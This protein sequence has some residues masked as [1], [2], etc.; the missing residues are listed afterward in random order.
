MADIHAVYGRAA[1]EGLVV[2]RLLWGEPSL[3]GAVRDEVRAARER[4]LDYEI[5]PGV[6]S[7]FAAAAALEIE[8]TVAPQSSRPLIL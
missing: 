5:V 4:G 1:R 6:T 3:Y 2:A 7:L 8:L